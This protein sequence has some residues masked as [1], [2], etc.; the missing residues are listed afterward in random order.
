MP[1]KL[2]AVALV[3]GACG[4][5]ASTPGDAGSDAPPGP[6]TW[7]NQPADVLPP[8]MFGGTGT[9]S[10]PPLV[11]CNY[12]ITL[13]QLDVRL[14]ILPSGQVTSGQVQDLNVEAVIPSTTPA[15]STT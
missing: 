1:W 14:T 12:T 13:R 15:C 8:A 10:T 9:A 4:S 7:R 6:V 2:P 5:V 11:F 3:L